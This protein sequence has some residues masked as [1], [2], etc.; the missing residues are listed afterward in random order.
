MKCDSELYTAASRTGKTIDTFV[1][2]PASFVIIDLVEG[3][4]M[5]NM[6]QTHQLI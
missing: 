5:L 3:N 2:D 4:P 1:H 6:K